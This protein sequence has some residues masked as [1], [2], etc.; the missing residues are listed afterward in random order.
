MAMPALGSSPAEGEVPAVPALKTALQCHH[1]HTWPEALGRP[2]A[3]PDLLCLEGLPENQEQ[4][5]QLNRRNEA[6]TLI[7]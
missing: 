3:P 4:I 2:E 7:D 5:Q 1:A 6:S